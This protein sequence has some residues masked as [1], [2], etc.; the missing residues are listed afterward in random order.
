MY[1]HVHTYITLNHYDLLSPS[2]PSS[3]AGGRGGKSLCGGGFMDTAPPTRTPTPTYI[4][5]IVYITYTQ[6]KANNIIGYWCY[7][8]WY[9][10]LYGGRRGV[11]I[12]QWQDRKHHNISNS[13]T[14]MAIYIRTI[15]LT[16]LSLPG[17]QLGGRSW[18]KVLV[19]DGL[20]QSP[21][22]LQ[23]SLYQHPHH[24]S[25]KTFV[26]SHMTVNNKMSGE[27]LQGNTI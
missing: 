20:I 8:I 1:V 9:M 27:N 10:Y 7:N 23:T 24:T 3:G 21:F 22:P 12:H 26:R 11:N 15:I 16:Y 18:H 19:G 6:S 13:N 14:S 25:L 17:C 2:C 4:H 5:K